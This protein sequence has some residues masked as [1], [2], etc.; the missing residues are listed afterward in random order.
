MSNV[1][2]SGGYYVAAGARVIIAQPQ[3]V[4]GSIGVV[5]ARFGVAPLLDRLGVFSD[6]VKRGERADLFSPARRLDE[7]ERALIE[8]EMEAVYQTFLGVVAKGRGKPV[9]AIAHLAEGRI[10]SG[11]DAQ[12]CG[13]VDAL[14][15]FDRALDMARS[16]LGPSG[17]G[18]EAR[19]IRP[20]RIKPPPPP[21]PRVI[22]ATLA[23]LGLSDL[24]AAL[25]LRASLGEERVLTYWAGVEHLG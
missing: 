11:V 17:R 18:L 10:Y 12:S 9:E 1:A 3:T 13:L 5:T 7:G 19:L 6:V 25:Q 20:P 16:L 14:G 22:Q 21:L 24:L 15:G 23:A 2:A 4:T 8:R